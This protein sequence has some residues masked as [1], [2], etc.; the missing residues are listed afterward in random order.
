MA[1]LLRDGHV[2]RMYF[3]A[4]APYAL[5]QEAGSYAQLLQQPAHCIQMPSGRS[6]D[7]EMLRLARAS[8]GCILSRDHFRDHR[9]R[10]RKLIDEPGRVMPGWVAE[11]H[12]LLPALNLRLA[13]PASAGAACEQLLALL[14]TA[15]SACAPRSAAA[16]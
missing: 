4:S 3:D 6:A 1:Q 16:R 5:R 2:A 8:G 13:L 7:G 14:A 9:R 11:H 10:Y 12:L 15:A